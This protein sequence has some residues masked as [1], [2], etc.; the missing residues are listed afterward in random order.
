MGMGRTQ[1]HFDEPKKREG[2]GEGEGLQGNLII[3]LQQIL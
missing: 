1:L 2:V 3:Q